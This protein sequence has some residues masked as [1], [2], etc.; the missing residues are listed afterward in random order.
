MMNLLLEG[1]KFLSFWAYL[2]LWS[3]AFVVFLYNIFRDQENVILL[4][5]NFE[6]HNAVNKQVFLEIL[7][8]ENQLQLGSIR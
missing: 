7:Q 3:C 6:H 1:P 2:M 8:R 4:T 5:D